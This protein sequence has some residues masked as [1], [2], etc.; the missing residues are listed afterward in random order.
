MLGLDT[1]YVYTKYEQSKPQ[2]VLVVR[3]CVCSMETEKTYT[4]RQFV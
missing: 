1:A 4:G 2:P 3:V